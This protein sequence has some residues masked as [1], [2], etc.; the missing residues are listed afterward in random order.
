[1][2]RHDFDTR[3]ARASVENGR[4]LRTWETS[5]GGSNVKKSRA[6]VG[7]RT[8]W[9]VRNTERGECR[10]RVRRKC[11]CRFGGSAEK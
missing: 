4:K 5:S 1:M 8:P 10:R 11:D 3:D 9:S 7:I 2:A 6:R